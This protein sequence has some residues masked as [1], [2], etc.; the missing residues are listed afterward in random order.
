[1]EKLRELFEEYKNSVDKKFWDKNSKDYIQRGFF[2]WLD[3]KYSE[4][5]TQLAIDCG[6]PTNAELR[7]K[8]FLIS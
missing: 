4:N 3:D 1:M 2:E 7:R 8:I 5:F 6:F